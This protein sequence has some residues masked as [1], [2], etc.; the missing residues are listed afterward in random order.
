[1]ATLIANP[2][3]NWH[4]PTI[5]KWTLGGGKS[6]SESGLTPIWMMKDSSN[7]GEF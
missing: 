2:Q 3:S 5:M 1:M 7:S 4:L 6:T